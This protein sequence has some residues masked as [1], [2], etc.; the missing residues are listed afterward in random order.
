MTGAGHH[1]TN[2]SVPLPLACFLDEAGVV[3]A[4]E[5]EVLKMKIRRPAA[6]E[7]FGIDGWAVSCS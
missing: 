7:A 4:S 3:K 2:L 1:R 5:W 6:G